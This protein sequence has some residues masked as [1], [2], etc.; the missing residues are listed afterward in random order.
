MCMSCS[1]TN[2]FGQLMTKAAGHRSPQAMPTGL[3]RRRF[4][5][6]GLACAAVASQVRPHAALA[7]EARPD[8]G[9]GGPPDTIF[10]GGTV[11]TLAADRPLAE[12][13]AVR[14]KTILAV[15]SNAE[16]DALAGPETR[17]IELA[18]RTMLPGFVEGHIHPFLGSFFT[19]GLDLQLPTRADALAAIARFAQDHPTG[20]LRGFG[21]R[22]DMF[23]PQ[24][25][26][27]EDLDRIVPDRP[28]FFFAIDGHSM[29]ANSKALE[30]AG[31]DRDTPDPI[32]GFSYYVR[33]AEG[34]PTG[35]VLEVAAVLAMVNKIEP[36]SVEAMAGLL[37]GWLPKAAAAGITTIYDAGVPPV[38]DDQGAI[39]E[40]YT[41][42]E[43]EGRLPFR[44]VASYMMKGPPIEHAVSGV[45]D[46][47]RRIDT[48]LVQARV[49]KIVGDGTA[50][51]YTAL[52]LEPYTDR[53]D[54]IGQSPFS[55]EQWTSMVTEADA[56]GID[57]HIHACG[58]GTTRLAL[59][60]IEAA[61]AAN[62]P[63]DRRHS[64][65]HLVLVDDA[66]MPRFA[67]LGANAQ[68]SANW[69]SAD[70]DTVDILLERYG[71]E[72]QRQIYRPRSILNAGG[73][74]SFGTDWP[75]AG[76][77][78]T[79]KPLDSIQIAVTRQL[80]GQP[81]AP[82]L[83]P[84]DERLEVEQAVHANTM[85]AARQLRM[86]DRIGS[87]EP[88]KLADLVV[89][90]QDIFGVGKHDIAKVRV[91]MTMMNGRFT[92]GGG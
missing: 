73:T 23:P 81:D 38:G 29:W 47:R 80:I 41:D 2:A 36:I 45:E 77:F 34:N 4:V 27:K 31:V 78:A 72:R 82:V 13:V 64:I 10:R 68:F 28:A 43:R 24:G 9:A 90:E 70:P 26:S 69:M 87:I 25:P 75:A 20:T 61:I 22:V 21:W 76:Y 85:G 58:E 65:A 92:H 7:Q 30:L 5:G 83:E 14:G 32:P 86:E 33:D 3:A 57:V 50:E 46:L 18:G 48:E 17:V 60:A 56:A 19:A 52:L 59:N 62:P 49:L 88:G 66:D 89:L 35:Y 11:R 84:A 1:L 74:I 71:P 63:R 44:V 42:L 16:I 15:G 54:T 6:A 53:P 40:V 37:E 55:Q 67:E 91:E 8:N 79:Y 39:I 51:G 12:A